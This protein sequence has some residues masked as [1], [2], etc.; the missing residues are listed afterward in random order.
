MSRYVDAD[1]API[2]LNTIA[3]EQI[4]YMPTADVVP[5]VHAHWI[6]GGSKD[7][8]INGTN[9]MHCSNCKAHFRY[10]GQRKNI[11]YCYKCGA[12]MDEEA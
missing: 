3:C 1:A 9:I 12:K 6:R 10:Y 7:W 2:Y 8:N 5:V 11:N 4:K